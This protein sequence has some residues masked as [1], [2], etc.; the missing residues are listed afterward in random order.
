MFVLDPV[1]DTCFSWIFT[2][3]DWEVRC[4]SMVINKVFR[5]IFLGTKN[6]VFRHLDFNINPVIFL[7]SAWKKVMDTR[8]FQKFQKFSISKNFQKSKNENFWKSCNNIFC[9]HR[10]FKLVKNLNTKHYICFG[11]SYGHSFFTGFARIWLRGQWVYNSQKQS[12]SFRKKWNQ[13]LCFSSF[14]F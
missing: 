10:R 8:N 11:P 12:F 7:K 6:F 14:G 4:L 9:L 3:F 1:T 5:S 2:N 13:K